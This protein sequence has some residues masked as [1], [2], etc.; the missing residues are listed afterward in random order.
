M[1]DRIHFTGFRNQTELPAYYQAS[2]AL[3]LPSDG[4]ETW[5]LVVNEAFSCGLPAIV[6]DAVGCA[7]DLIEEERTGLTFS[8]GSIDQ[9]S[10]QMVKLMRLCDSHASSI[11]NAVH[12]KVTEY[13]MTTATKGLYVAMDALSV[14]HPLEFESNE[15]EQE[16]RGPG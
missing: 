7:P 14:S 4:D 13:S 15:I 9:L 1:T 10:T 12:E 5:G 6:S 8:C 16:L 3:I 11:S 2:N